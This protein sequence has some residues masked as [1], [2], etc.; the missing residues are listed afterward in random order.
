MQGF[1]WPQAQPASKYAIVTMVKDD[2]FFLD[3]MIKHYQRHL[4]ADYF[5]IDHASS[6]D[7][8][9]WATINHPN[10]NINVITIPNIPFDDRFKSAAISSIANICA[11]CYEVTISSDADEIVMPFESSDSLQN[12]LDNLEHTF[13]APVGVEFVHNTN[14]ENE[15]DSNKD[16]TEQRN[17]FFFTSGYSKPVI[18]KKQ[19]HFSP[20][21]H[22][23]DQPY[24][25]VSKLALVHLRSVDFNQI[26]SRQVARMN[27]ILSDEQEQKFSNAHWKKDVNDKAWYGNW[28]FEKAKGVSKKKNATDLNEFLDNVGTPQKVN[29]P[30]YRH[31]ISKVSE[32]LLWK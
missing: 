21:L 16:L 27:S 18:W 8:Q 19:S 11:A 2:L 17:T 12:T 7:V 22:G 31:D 13:S 6:I 5:I 32:L 28:I 10:L 3:I 4:E 23:I 9:S 14:L 30:F 29:Q 15:Y 1:F 20:G 26:K 25:I 24:S